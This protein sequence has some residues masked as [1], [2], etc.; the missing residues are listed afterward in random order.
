MPSSYYGLLIMQIVAWIVA[1]FLISINGYLLI[2]YIVSEM[3]GLL[4]SSIVCTVL[5]IYLAF[6]IYLIG[7]GSSLSIFRN[8]S[9]NS[10]HWNLD[11]SLDFG[12]SVS[13]SV[14]QRSLKYSPTL[15]IQAWSHI[16]VRHSPNT[17]LWILGQ[18]L[19]GY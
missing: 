14:T 9:V 15:R 12:M 7:H 3:Q 18:F 17:S 16:L 10:S 6:V 11:P 2:D 4:L 19:F 13:F 1:A 5:A 8:K